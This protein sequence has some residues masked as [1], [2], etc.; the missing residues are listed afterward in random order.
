MTRIILAS[1]SRHRQALLSAAGIDFEAM[2]PQVDERAV[3]AALGPKAASGDIVAVVLAQAKAEEVSA[4]FG[5][6]L[7]I[8]ADQTLAL[9]DRLFHKPA[10]IG[11]A[12][13]NLLALRGRTHQLHSAVCLA[14]A[15]KMV[16]SHLATADMTMREFDPGFAGRYLARIGDR[17]LASVG[18]YQVEAE[19][20]QL[21]ER[22]EG[23]FLAIVGLPL[24]PLLAQLRDRGAIDG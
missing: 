10:T 20:I 22:I 6:A 23:D 15:G 5:D 7:V 21:F 4:R 14:I 16:W 12:R 17:A 13:R 3:E 11:E 9:G 8:G 2:A 19:G 18:V 1:A 24:L